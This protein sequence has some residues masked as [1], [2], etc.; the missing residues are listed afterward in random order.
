MWS[1]AARQ[2]GLYYNNI[3]SSTGVTQTWDYNI[4][5]WEASLS[6]RFRQN[7]RLRLGYQ[8]TQLPDA[9]D[10]SGHLVAMQLQVWT[11]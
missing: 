9:P 5:R 4:W 1:V 6:Y 7:T 10:L 3:T 8:S 11:R 2:E